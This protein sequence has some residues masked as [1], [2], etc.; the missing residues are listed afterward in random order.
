VGLQNLGLV[1]L[2]A[3]P[4]SKALDFSLSHQLKRFPVI[5]DEI[6]NSNH[7]KALMFELMQ[8]KIA[9]FLFQEICLSTFLPV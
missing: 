4:Q 6:R 5:A 8:K 9:W 7:D 3:G 1:H 2:S